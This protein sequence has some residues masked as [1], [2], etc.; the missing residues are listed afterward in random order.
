MINVRGIANAAIQ[1]VNPNGPGVLRS[2]TGY[3]TDAAGKRTPSYAANAAV[4]LQVQAAK[5]SQLEHVE[6]L[7]LQNTYRNVRMEGNTQG[8]VR[9]TGKGG[10]LLQFPETPGGTIRVWLVVAVL[11]TWRDWCSLIVCLQTD[12]AVP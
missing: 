3:T 1:P 10:D 12:A 9:V 2:S 6:N 5:T 4:V 11:E 8:A 7:N